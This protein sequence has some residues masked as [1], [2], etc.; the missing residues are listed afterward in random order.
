ML[1]LN[2]NAD[3][4]GIGI[5]KFTAECNA[6]VSKYNKRARARAKESLTRSSPTRK[7]V[8]HPRERERGLHY[9]VYNGRKAGAGERG[10]ER[11]ARV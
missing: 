1:V 5:D 2:N 3:N 8:M 4:G 9:A 11:G 7:R 10:G 6:R